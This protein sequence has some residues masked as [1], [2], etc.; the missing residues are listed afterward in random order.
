MAQA[1]FIRVFLLLA[2]AIPYAAFGQTAFTAKAVKMRAGPSPDFPVVSMVR[3]SVSVQVAGCVDDWT[4]C[5]VTAGLDRGWVYAGNL[6]YPYQGRRVTILANGPVIGLPIITFS[7]GPYW[8][9]YYRGRPW[10][11]RR[12]YWIGRPPPPHWI[13]RPPR[14]RP[15]AVIQPPRP[16]PP[17]V[18]QPPRPRPPAPRPP[19]PRPPRPGRPVVTP[20][21]G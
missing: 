19:A 13:G 18:I 12:S 17:A 6:V 8:D 4:W 1:W 21:A 3:P 20:R 15:P 5:D 2:M 9:S 10:Y 14:P 7:I 11:G 16:R